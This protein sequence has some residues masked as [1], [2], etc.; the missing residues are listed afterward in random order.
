MKTEICFVLLL[1]V[2]LVWVMFFTLHMDRIS[3]KIEKLEQLHTTG[4]IEKVR[5]VKPVVVPKGKREV[6]HVHGENEHEH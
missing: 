2:F 4:H 6:P 5:P 3:R 1:F